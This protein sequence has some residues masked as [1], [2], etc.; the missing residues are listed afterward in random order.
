MQFYPNSVALEILLLV[1]INQYEL[2]D[3]A[4]EEFTE[5][6]ALIF[7]FTGALGL[8]LKSNAAKTITRLR[9]S[10]NPAIKF[11]RNLELALVGS[12]STAIMEH[13]SADFENEK[14]KSPLVRW[15]ASSAR[16]PDPFHAVQYGKVM[17]LRRAR[18]LGLGTRYGCQCG[19]E[20]VHPKN[21]RALTAFRERLPKVL[22]NE[23]PKQIS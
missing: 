5:K 22:K 12:L 8:F 6:A 23:I 1:G 3:E 7:A 16:D 15:I 11:G 18:T 19:F 2:Y 9:A 4:E 21:K 20:F 17:S 14:D 10:K 13:L